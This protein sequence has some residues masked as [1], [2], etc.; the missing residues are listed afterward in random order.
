M[1]ETTPQQLVDVINEG[2]GYLAGSPDGVTACG[3]LIGR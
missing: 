3:K 1:A 2:E